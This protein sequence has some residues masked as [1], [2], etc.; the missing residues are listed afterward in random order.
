LHG[1]SLTADRVAG[2][3]GAPVVFAPVRPLAECL[4]MSSTGQRDRIARDDVVSDVA[5][6][7]RET[8]TIMPGSRAAAHYGNPFWSS[9]GSRPAGATL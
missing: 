3:Y 5:M 1:D 8:R 4:G 9:E 7:V 2:D 6:I